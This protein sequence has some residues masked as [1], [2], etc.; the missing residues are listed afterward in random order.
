MNQD[1]LYDEINDFLEHLPSGFS[2]L[3]EQIDINIQMLYFD[4][5]EKMQLKSLD[6]EQIALKIG[7]L[8]LNETSNDEKES[9]LIELAHCDDVTA[10]RA[11][12]NFRKA[13][14]EGHLYAWSTLA[15]QDS[16]MLLESSLLEEK[17]VFISTGM[18]GKGDKLRYFIVNFLN[19]ASG[20]PETIQNIIQKEFEYGLSKA[21]A[22][23]ET[24]TFESKYTLVT[25]LIPIKTDIRE[26]FQNINNEC[27]QLGI[28]LSEHFLVTNVKRLNV[29]EIEE[30][31]Q[32]N[33]ENNYLE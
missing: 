6:Q 3:E 12:E 25:A 20:Y 9:L 7:L 17:Q 5:R 21:K 33:L 14:P 8:H 24:I 27:Q 28:D 18:G 13:N 22:E 11:I 26:L 15:W 23:L 31:I 32:K 10:Y 4:Q 30:F 2:I 29:E 16:R 19:S 1:E